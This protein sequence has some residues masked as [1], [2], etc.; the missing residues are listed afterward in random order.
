MTIALCVDLDH[1]LIRTDSLIEG[2][3]AL[4]KRRPQDLARLPLWLAR[5]RA[6]FKAK[7]A[8]RADLNPASLPYDEAVLELVR[9]ARAAGR[10]AWLVTAADERTAEAVA[11]NLGL[12]DGTISNTGGENL[13]GEAK[14]RRLVERFGEK[15][16]DYAGDSA[17]DLPVWRHA[18][19]ALVFGSESLARKAAGIAEIERHVVRRGADGRTILDAARVYQWIKN[20]LIFV[21]LLAAHRAGNGEAL[22]QTLVAFLAF[23]LCASSVYIVNDLLD[24][25]ADRAH[26]RKRHRPFASGT[27]SLGLGL[28]LAP[29]LLAGAAALCATLPPAFG[30][31]LAAYYTATLAYSFVLKHY[32]L[33][34]IFTLAGLYTAR[35]VAAAAAG[36][37]PLSFWLL[38]FSMFLFLSLAALKRYG[39]LDALGR[40]NPSHATSRGYFVQ[41]LAILQTLGASAGFIAVLV[42]A[43]YINSPEVTALYR[44]PEAIWALCA[45]VL[46]WIS[47][48]WLKAHRGAMHDDPIVFAARD[49]ISLVVLGAS[50]AVVL[51]AV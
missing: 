37:V 17:A 5:G 44:L 18:R 3:L 14:A 19:R 2:V 22:G 47:R 7:I 25:A 43:L 38:L 41:D 50:G 11:R 40:E 45:L 4:V 6:A 32:V 36:T 39:E 48:M 10:S 24:L 21:P 8:Q 29:A 23:G 42:L 12:F 16:F 34:D 27:L 9:A 30:L 1:T 46:Y 13:K 49:W 26:P 20:V 33:V 28:A 35:I 51:L 31:A 15:G